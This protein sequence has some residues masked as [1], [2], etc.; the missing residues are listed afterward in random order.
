MV[1]S[2]FTK[3]MIRRL[4]RFLF[5]VFGPEDLAERLDY[6][7]KRVSILEEESVE[8]INDIYEIENIIESLKNNG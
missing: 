1:P 6:L 5:G 7:E 8:F 4:R 2:Y 3:S